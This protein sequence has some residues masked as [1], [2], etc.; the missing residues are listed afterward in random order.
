MRKV[1]LGAGV[2]AAV[3]GVLTLLVLLFAP[4]IAYCTTGALHTCPAQAIQ[5]QS[6]PQAGADIGVYGY[7][8]GMALVVLAGAGGAIAEARYGLRGGIVPLWTGTI[9]AFMG[10]ALAAQGIGLLYLPDVLAL[11]LAAYASLMQRRTFIRQQRDALAVPAPVGEPDDGAP[12]RDPSV[13]VNAD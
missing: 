11:T 8:V 4:L 3:I 5:Y 2:G 9:M 13:G 12:T 10:C 1:E 6:L 7:L